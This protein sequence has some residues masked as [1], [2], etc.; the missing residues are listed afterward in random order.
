MTKNKLFVIAGMPRSG[1]TFMYHN[2]QKHPQLFLPFR[3]EIGYFGGNYERGERWFQKHFQKI[4]TEK[5]YV[6][7]TPDYAL[8][9]ETVQRIKDYSDDVFV[10]L[11]IRKPSEVALSLYYQ[12]SFSEKMPPFKDFVNRY[13]FLIGWE[14][15]KG[16]YLRVSLKEGVLLET[17]KIYQKTFADQLL[18]Y[19]YELFKK[20]TFIVLTAIEIFLGLDPYFTTDNYD[21]IIINANNRNTLPYIEV[22]IRNEILVSLIGKIL[23]RNIVHLIR[24]YFDKARQ[25]VECAAYKPIYSEEELACANELFSEQDAEYQSMFSDSKLIIGSGYPFDLKQKYS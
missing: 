24:S 14:K 23:P 19:D 3:K 8:N 25:P 17:M 10:V 12:L 4:K 15:L 18:L 5:Y 1:T 13:T 20:N 16:A 22:L 2:L 9:Q 11:G 6:D 21:D 7:I